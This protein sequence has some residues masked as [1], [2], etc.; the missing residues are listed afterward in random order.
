MKKTVFPFLLLLAFTF[1]SCDEDGNLKLNSDL[2][3]EEIAEGLKEALKIG[4]D[5]ASAQLSAQDGYYR[6][7]AVKILLP[8]EVQ[9]SITDFQAKSFTVLGVTVTGQN[10]YDGYSNSLLGINIPGLKSKE[11]DLVQGINRAAEQAA[12]TAAP[13]FVDA[14]VDITIADA[15]DI[16]FGGNNHAATEY[17][18]GKTS[19]KLYNEYEPKIDAALTSVKVGNT[20]VVDSY[21]NFVA[22]YNAVL[23]TSVGVGTIGS[24]MGVQSIATTDLSAHATQKGLD[25]LFLKV[26]EE[27]EDIRKDPLARVNA[28]LTR[29]FGALD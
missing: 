5:T 10:L 20:S 6:D 15:N 24:L 3:E 18:E 21:E 12:T 1:T 17:L 4:T 14:I 9:T 13:I 25:G 8:A 7:L 23:N 22:D 26:S 2:T 11:D 29:V 28:I 19:G 27:E 16:L